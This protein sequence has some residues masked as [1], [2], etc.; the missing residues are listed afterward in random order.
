LLKAD[1]KIAIC[2]NCFKTCPIVSIRNTY[3]TRMFDYKSDWIYE[4]PVLDPQCCCLCICIFVER[5]SCVRST[6]SLSLYFVLRGRT[7]N[8]KVVCS[9]HIPLYLC[10]E[11]ARRSYVRSTLFCIF[12]GSCVRSA[13][14]VS[15]LGKR[16]CILVERA[17]DW[18]YESRV[19]DPHSTELAPHNS[20]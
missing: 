13:L 11:S 19:C 12:V 2:L 6:M 18:I 7:E 1:F 8:M 9:I 3:Y 4:G 15:L 14:L 5:G 17:A 16:L 10:L 20:T